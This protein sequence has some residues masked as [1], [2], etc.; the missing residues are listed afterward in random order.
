MR[1]KD[2]MGHFTGDGL[3]VGWRGGSVGRVEMSTTIMMGSSIIG[4]G[5]RATGGSSTLTV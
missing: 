2:Y 3:G 5:W 1:T 4:G